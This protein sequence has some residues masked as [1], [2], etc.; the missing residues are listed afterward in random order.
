MK[1]MFAED[2][3][4][5]RY[6]SEASRNQSAVARNTRKAGDGAVFHPASRPTCNAL[7]LPGSEPLSPHPSNRTQ[8]GDNPTRRT[9]MRNPTNHRSQN[10]STAQKASAEHRRCPKCKRGSALVYHSDDAVSGHYCRW[11]DCNYENFKLLPGMERG[12]E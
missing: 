8:V 5:I 3:L 9:M 11:N 6:V 10:F 2:A 12:Y 7:R 1:E 4:A